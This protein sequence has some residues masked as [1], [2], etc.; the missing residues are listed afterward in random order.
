MKSILQLDSKIDIVK[1]I[2]I[3]LMVFYHAGAPGKNFVYLFHMDLF[4]ISSGYC[5]RH[6]S[7]KKPWEYVKR[8]I[9]TLYVPFVVY[10]S[11]N[12]SEGEKDGQISDHFF[13]RC[14]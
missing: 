9:L 1:A 7:E 10:N 3:I 12:I 4:F 5:Y 13:M 2:G 6:D 11:F 14:L 8:E